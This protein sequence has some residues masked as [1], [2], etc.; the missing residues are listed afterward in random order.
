MPGARNLHQTEA[1]ERARLL[2]VASYDI[3]I[4]LS[5]AADPSLPTTFRCTTEVRFACREPDASTFIEV[6]AAGIRSATLNG[7]PV[8]TSGWSADRGLDLRRLD[9][10]NTLIVEADFEYNAAGQGL[11]RAVDPEDGEVYLYTQF[12]PADAQRVFACFDQPD[13]KASFTWHATVPER[14]R[15]V[16]TMTE[17]TRDTTTDGHT[18][19]HFE[20]SPRISTYVTALCAGPY[21]ELRRAHDGI[22]LGLFCRA[23]LAR[24]LIPDFFFD[25]TT[26]GWTSSRTGSACAIRWRSTT[27]SW[28]RSS[29]ERWRTSAASPTA[30]TSPSSGARRRTHSWSF[31]PRSCCTSWPTCGSATS[32]PCGG[33]T[34]CGST[35]RS[36]PG[37]PPGP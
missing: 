27:R 23:S 35:S 18:T 8:D 3:T 11:H 28:C 24:H 13:L 20:P 9:A 14:W 15:V 17:Q 16:S 6:A 25:V 21:H 26:H 32:S 10:D 36:P 4:D 12:Q 5:D 22:D 30:R 7:V 37:P 34:I 19:I 31:W 29:A 2:D 1:D 33:G